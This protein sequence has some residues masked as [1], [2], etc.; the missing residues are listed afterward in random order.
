MS[1]ARTVDVP[2]S[3]GL[4]YEADLEHK[5]HCG[6]SRAHQQY[7]WMRC[8]LPHRCVRHD[9]CDSQEP[10]CVNAREKG[11]GRSV[12]TDHNA[13]TVVSRLCMWFQKFAVV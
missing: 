4:E 3:L 9:C 10:D 13:M 6:E 2:Y 8:L 7:P 12:D 1:L 11:P 5:P